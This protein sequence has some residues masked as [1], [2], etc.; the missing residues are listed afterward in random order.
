M[1]WSGKLEIEDR[2]YK[3]AAASVS[4]NSQTPMLSRLRAIKC[5]FLSTELASCKGLEFGT[6]IECAMG[7][8]LVQDLVHWD[9]DATVGH[10]TDRICWDSESFVSS[11]A[12][13]SKWSKLDL[14][15]LAEIV[16]CCGEVTEICEH[17]LVLTIESLMG[18]AVL[19]IFRLNS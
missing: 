13:G 4:K 17:L 10:G 9:L 19:G 6:F 3:H 8:W 7:D 2:A 14:V 1:C 15:A 16:L 18:L 11:K 12:R 5:S